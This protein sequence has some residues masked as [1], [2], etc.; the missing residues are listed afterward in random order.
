MTDQTKTPPAVAAA[1]F[2]DDRP[3][4]TKPGELPPEIQAPLAPF[5]G[6]AP[7][8]PAW[9]EAAIAKEPQRSFVT[10]LGTQI[11]VLTWGEVGKP[12]LLLVHGNSAHADWWS[13]IAPYL[14]EDYRVVSMSLAGMGAS[15]WRESYAFQD[16]A[17]DAEAVAKATG[18]Y[19]GGRKPIYIGHSF[20]GS[21]VFYAASRYPERMHAAILVDTGFGGPPPREQEEMAR[22]MEQVRNIP[23]TDRPKRVYA[24]LEAALARFRFMPPQAPGHLFVA[25]FIARRSLKRAPL[26]DGS[27]E[28]WAW[29]FDPA[30]WNKLDRSAMNALVT[31]GPPKVEVPIAHI[32]GE[33]SQV[34]A[35]RHDGRANP[36]PKDMI[37]IAIP[38]SNHH[39]MVDQ[40]LALIAALRALLAVWPS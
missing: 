37:E 33:L 14:A 34:I 30:M 11:E 38:D 21:Q 3:I 7:P 19:E 8:A 18:L 13:F 39:V 32:Y 6:E 40:P 12:G 28:G 9:F 25:D 2:E 4:Q 10:S 16:F 20:G 24:T 17:E 5:K 22:R 35:R 23:T 36:L 1:E 29:M 27:G 26:E 31:E 15:D